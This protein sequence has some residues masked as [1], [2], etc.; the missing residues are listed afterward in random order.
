MVE[1]GIVK[2]FF[3]SRSRNKGRYG[4][5][6]VL[7][8]NNK[9]TGEEVFFRLDKA[10]ELIITEPSPT[11]SQQALRRFVDPEFSST[12]DLGLSEPS[13]GDLVVFTANEGSPSRAV[14]AWT[15]KDV[16]EDTDWLIN[17]I[18]YADF[19]REA[20][21]SE[22]PGGCGESVT[23]CVCYEIASHAAHNADPATL[24]SWWIQ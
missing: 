12:R 6:E 5:I 15:L 19:E 22:C 13:E 8:E 16:W 14:T 11:T 18:P 23:N 24:N 10:R 9:P 2:V 7:D 3:G 20:F 1:F 17:N 4:F 21:E